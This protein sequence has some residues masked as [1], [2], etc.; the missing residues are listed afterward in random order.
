MIQDSSATYRRIGRNPFA[1]TSLHKL[2]HTYPLAPK[3]N[4]YKDSA[5]PDDGMLLALTSGRPP[6]AIT[7]Q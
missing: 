2:T 4:C 3:T 7:T 1:V 5:S 6:L